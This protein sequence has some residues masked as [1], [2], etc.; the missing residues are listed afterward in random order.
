MKTIKKTVKKSP[1]LLDDQGNK[2]KLRPR[3]YYKG[4]H[5][6]NTILSKFA[7]F[8]N[9]Y[10]VSL[11]GAAWDEILAN[12]SVSKL[13]HRQSWTQIMPL[14][15][16]PT[17][18]AKFNEDKYDKVSH[19]GDIDIFKLTP[20]AWIKAIARQS[21]II[22]TAELHDVGKYVAPVWWFRERKDCVTHAEKS[23]MLDKLLHA[24]RIKIAY[25]DFPDVRMGFAWLKD[26]NPE[27]YAAFIE[28]VLT[29]APSAMVQWVD[30][31]AADILG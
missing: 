20:S 24:S 14:A 28:W 23:A 18:Y 19:K 7:Q 10:S 15:K 21:S 6:N 29:I 16:H 17:E 1:P 12:T 4:E 25:K 30:E 9:M 31:P 13:D 26:T 22:T 3:G 2:V 27:V 5:G 11:P 8:F